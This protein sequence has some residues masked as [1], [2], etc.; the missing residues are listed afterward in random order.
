MG[1]REVEEEEEE[2]PTLPRPTGCLGHVEDRLP[3]VCAWTQSAK[4]ASLESSRSAELK[5]SLHA[6]MAG[7]PRRKPDDDD[8]DDAVP[9]W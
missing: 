6:S 3:S 5:T 2:E 7:L 8:D 1:E 9:W 4:L